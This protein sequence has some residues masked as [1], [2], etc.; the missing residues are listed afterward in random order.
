MRQVII[1]ELQHYS[2]SSVAQSGTKNNFL[3]IVLSRKQCSLPNHHC[4]RS[5]GSSTFISSL[6]LLV[7]TQEELLSLNYNSQF[8]LFTFNAIQPPSNP[9]IKIQDTEFAAGD[10]NA[11]SFSPSSDELL[12]TAD[13]NTLNPTAHNVFYLPPVS[14]ATNL[15]SSFTEF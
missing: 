5:G 4:L 10:L 8:N 3:S 7:S 13:L 12:A 9:T 15:M 11:Y 14:F 6:P 2:D 1:C